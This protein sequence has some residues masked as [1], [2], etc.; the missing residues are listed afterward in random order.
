[1]LVLRRSRPEQNISLEWNYCSA[2][3]DEIIS[4]AF[5]QSSLVLLNA[6]D[7]RSIETVSAVGK[8]EETFCII[9]PLSICGI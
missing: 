2:I 9:N 6:S 4:F 7:A 8:T 5:G 3:F 1:M